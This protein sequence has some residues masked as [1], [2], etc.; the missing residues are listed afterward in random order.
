[1]LPLL[2]H[3]A[4]QF[5][6]SG[7]DAVI[8]SSSGFAK[9]IITRANVPHICYCHAP[10]RY[11]WDMAAEA[12]A[13]RP[14]MARWPLR[15]LQH[16]LRLVDFTAAQ[17]V[18]IFLANSRFTHRRIHSYYRRGSEV[19][20]PPIDTAFFTPA[21]KQGKD[22]DAPFLLVGRLTRAKHFDAAIRVCEKLHLPLVVVGRGQDEARL[23][24]IKH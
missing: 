6:F 22:P 18:D 1:M 24:R 2:P 3:A 13:T 12:V 7:Y 16:Y 14:R 8:S 23:K 15:V 21:M 9:A 4:E 5:D 17:R 10:T 11:L 19:V 20:Y